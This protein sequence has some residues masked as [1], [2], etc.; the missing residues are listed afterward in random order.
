MYVNKDVLKALKNV[1]QHLGSQSL[2]PELKRSV[3]VLTSF[4]EGVLK[5]EIQKETYKKSSRIKFH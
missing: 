1:V 4:L 5:I 2:E 3:K